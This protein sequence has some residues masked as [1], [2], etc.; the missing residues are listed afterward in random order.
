MPMGA[1][2]KRARN[3]SSLSR[4]TASACRSGIAEHFLVSAIRVNVMAMGI[5]EGNADGR[6]FKKGAKSFLAFAQHGLCL[7]I[8]NSRAFPGKRDSCERNGHGDRGGQCRWAPIQK[9]REIFP[10][11]RAARPLPADR[12]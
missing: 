2:S 11:F 7:Q 6:R 10:R 9:G 4:S 3:L 5:V 12:E 8:G 1:D